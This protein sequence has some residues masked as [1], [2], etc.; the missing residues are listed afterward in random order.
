[1]PSRRSC[2][3]QSVKIENQ[4]FYLSVGEYVDGRPGE[5][6]LEAN[7]MNTFARG[8]LDSLARITS[9]AL[10]CGAPITDICSAL[11]EM[12]FPPAGTVSGS[13]FISEATSISDWIAQELEQAYVPPIS[14]NIQ[15]QKTAGHFSEEWRTGA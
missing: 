15:T 14:G 3:T 12:Y 8:A 6:W 10:Q 4:R 2:W 5:I 13:Q 1:M 9:V 7:K 11:R